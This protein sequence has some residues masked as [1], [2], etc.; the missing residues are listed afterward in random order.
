[1]KR[2][3]RKLGEAINAVATVQ[4]KTYSAASL[5]DNDPFAGAS[6]R[7]IS[8]IRLDGGARIC[9]PEKDGQVDD[10]LWKLHADMVEKALA[11]RVEMFK[12]AASAAQSLIGVLKQL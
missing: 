12:L 1:M 10:A 3:T 9:V 2:Y 7:A 8:E 5:N 4:V 6:L 11:N